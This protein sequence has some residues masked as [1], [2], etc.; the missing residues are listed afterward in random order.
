MIYRILWDKCGLYTII[1]CVCN[2]LCITWVQCFY[3]PVSTI[4]PH[5]GDRNHKKWYQEIDVSFAGP[6]AMI[7]CANGLA[8]IIKPTIFIALIYVALCYTYISCC[9]V[10]F[11]S[12]NATYVVYHC[13]QLFSPD[14][15]DIQSTEHVPPITARLGTHPDKNRSYYLG[16]HIHFSYVQL[17]W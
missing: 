3:H 1:L 13:M 6:N 9:G 5:L 10:H 16:H 11:V 2:Y 12:G 7:Q 8:R 15:I 4:R 17:R 14:L